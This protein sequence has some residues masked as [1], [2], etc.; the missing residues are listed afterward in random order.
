MQRFCV[1]AHHLLPCL[2]LV[3]GL[4][5]SL[6]GRP[7]K[8]QCGRGR[9][10]VLHLG[11]LARPWRAKGKGGPHG[12]QWGLL[13]LSSP[14][15]SVPIWQPRSTWTGKETAGSRKSSQKSPQ[16]LELPH[17]QRAL[18]A[19]L[20]PS[21]FLPACLSCSPACPCGPPSRAHPFTLWFSFMHL[22]CLF[23]S[24]ALVLVLPRA[25]VLHNSRGRPTHRCSLSQAFF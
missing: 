22:F 15:F 19:S 16:G 20:P 25:A 18:S 7:G 3:P 10:A 11:H 14:S 8:E 2:T 9:V 13:G 6:T 12:T 4:S 23:P 21:L 17:L 5:L 1:P 24:A